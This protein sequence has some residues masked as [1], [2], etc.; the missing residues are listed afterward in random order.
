MRW[1]SYPGGGSLCADGFRLTGPLDAAL[2]A[3][4]TRLGLEAGDDWTRLRDEWFGNRFLSEGRYKPAHRCA[5]R[6]GKER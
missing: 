4:R 1:M 3:L 5:G 6:I 2:S